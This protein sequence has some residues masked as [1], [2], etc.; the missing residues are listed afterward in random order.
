MIGLVERRAAHACQS[1]GDWLGSVSAASLM[2]RGA[3]V[4]RAG[5]TVAHALA[6]M[7]R[8]EVDLLAV[9]DEAG[10][11]VGVIDRDAIVKPGRPDPQGTAQTTV[12]I[13]S[14]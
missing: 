8:F 2:R 11:V 4:G 1:G 6:T 12:T 14:T 5:D 10:R 13:R 3:F 9:I 7:D